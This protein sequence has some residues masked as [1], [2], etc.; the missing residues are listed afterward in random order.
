MSEMTRG[1]GDLHSTVA[2]LISVIDESYEVLNP[3]LC[4][5]QPEAIRELP[6]IGH[7]TLNEMS[8]LTSILQIQRNK[9]LRAAQLAVP[10]LRQRDVGDAF[11]PLLTEVTQ[12][13][14][15][16]DFCIELLPSLFGITFAHALEGDPTGG[17]SDALIENVLGLQ[18]VV[19]HKGEPDECRRE[20][21]FEVLTSILKRDSTHVTDPL[22]YYAAGVRKASRRIQ[23]DRALEER[24]H[25][26]LTPKERR[27][28]EEERRARRTL[29]DAAVAFKDWHS[30]PFSAPTPTPEDIV[31]EL[32]E[33]RDRDQEIESILATWPDDQAAIARLCLETGA[34]LPQARRE[35]RLPEKAE[36]ALRSRLHRWEKK[37]AA[38]E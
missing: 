5:T 9:L 23:R 1:N 38:G 34:S 22:S 35:L 32:S 17:S 12:L 28:S 26:G 18:P 25:L 13:L 37:R 15:A 2:E 8:D 11:R 36:R 31:I 6:G 14:R 19:K 10:E 24:D 33:Q 27:L 29:N 21:A 7:G 3:Y 4:W 20:G 30:S 16:F